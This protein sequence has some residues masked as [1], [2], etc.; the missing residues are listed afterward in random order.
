MLIKHLTLFIP[1]NI[2]NSLEK[3]L[4]KYYNYLL[5]NNKQFHDKIEFDIVPTCLTSN[6]KNLKKEFRKKKFSDKEINF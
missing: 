4:L 6:F 3:K 2:S 5:S 1:K